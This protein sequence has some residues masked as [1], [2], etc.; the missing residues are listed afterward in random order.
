LIVNKLRAFCAFWYDFVIGDDWR[1]A[2]TV[3]I[4]LAVTI[5]AGR[6]TGVAPWWVLVAAVAVALPV[7]IYRVIR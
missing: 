2:L 4:A 7:S 1:V 3:A 6:L 5:V